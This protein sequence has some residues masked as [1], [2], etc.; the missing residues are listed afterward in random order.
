MRSEEF[1]REGAGFD[2]EAWSDNKVDDHGPDLM[3]LAK[4][5]PIEIPAWDSY[6]MDMDDGRPDDGDENVAADDSIGGEVTS[7]IRGHMDDIKKV[8]FVGKTEQFKPTA[9]TIK[10]AQNIIKSPEFKKAY[11]STE[12]VK[13]EDDS[14][15]NRITKLAGLGEGADFLGYLKQTD[16]KGQVTWSFPNTMK[17]NTPHRSNHNARRILQA[18][19]LP[20]D[21]ENEGPIPLDQFIKATRNYMDSHKEADDDMYDNVEMYDQEALRFKA[22]HPEIT[23]VAFA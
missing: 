20:M 7:A 6:Y 1:I 16:D 2:V 13:A 14:E 12:S 3:R 17:F 18:L 19:G 21:F 4:G 11:H 8:G 10:Y 5:Q 22:N 9:E 23:H 15:L